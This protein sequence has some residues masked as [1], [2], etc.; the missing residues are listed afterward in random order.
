MVV[1]IIF[2][3]LVFYLRNVNI[4]I[5]IKNITGMTENYGATIIEIA[6]DDFLKT[7]GT[8]IVNQK[9]EE[10]VLRGYNLGL[11]LS[12]SAYI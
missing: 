2:S 4:D 12:K 1:S 8:K 10:V 7:S 3:I 5:E 6:D 11:W 9:G